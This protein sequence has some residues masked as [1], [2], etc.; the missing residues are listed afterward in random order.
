[1]I[2]NLHC[3]CLVFKLLFTIAVIILWYKVRLCTSA[4]NLGSKVQATP[5]R[6]QIAV[7]IAVPIAKIAR[8]SHTEGFVKSGHIYIRAQIRK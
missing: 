1:M 7:N 3:M 8:G 4:I 6:T 5:T 2:R